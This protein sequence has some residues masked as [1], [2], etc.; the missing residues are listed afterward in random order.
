MNHPTRRPAPRPR[1]FHPTDTTSASE[2]ASPHRAGH[3]A[4]LHSE[5]APRITTADVQRHLAP[6]KRP[7][8][9]SQHLAPRSAYRYQPI[10]DESDEIGTIAMP[11]GVMYRQGTQQV[12]QHN[13]PRQYRRGPARHPGASPPRNTPHPG[14][15]YRCV[16]RSL[17]CARAEPGGFT[18]S[19]SW[20]SR[21]SSW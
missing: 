5:D 17:R 16:S 10:S 9:P 1:I 11:D 14:R 2:P 4:G 7:V 15:S 20:V 19:D 21:F 13:G 18:G 12:Y 3:Y 8:Y 6:A